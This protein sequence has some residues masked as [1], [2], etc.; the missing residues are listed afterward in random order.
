MSRSLCRAVCSA[1]TLLWI[2]AATFLAPVLR[3]LPEAAS[4]RAF[5]VLMPLSLA[6]GAVSVIMCVHGWTRYRQ[7]LYRAM[8]ILNALA[9]GLLYVSAFTDRLWPYARP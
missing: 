8:F 3:S 7:N 6:C 4:M 9:F 5:L 1:T 2:G